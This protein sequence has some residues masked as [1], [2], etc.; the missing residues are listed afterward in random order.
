MICHRLECLTRQ[1]QGLQPFT[2]DP[3]QYPLCRYCGCV[4]E[5]KCELKVSSE[6]VKNLLDK[7]LEANRTIEVLKETPAVKW[8]TMTSRMVVNLT[9]N[10]ADNIAELT[11]CCGTKA[12][13]AAEFCV[14]SL[15]DIDVEELV[16]G[17][18]N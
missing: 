5:P 8:H 13:K 1:T 11:G 4:I 9:N 17:F 3:S 7:L 16:K 18:D 2:V 6:Q 10:L 12:Q 14:K 15:V